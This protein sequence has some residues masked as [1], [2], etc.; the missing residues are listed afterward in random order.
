M[1]KLRLKTDKIV[2]LYNT[3]NIF[4]NEKIPFKSAVKI[5]TNIEKLKIINEQFENKRTE[6]IK[7]YGEKDENGEVI[8]MD[9][10][11]IKIE[12]VEAFNSSFN[13]ILQEEFDL[14]LEE[15]SM[16]DLEEIKV[17]ANDIYSISEILTE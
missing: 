7:E 14:E 11:R 4:A 3:L 12:N 13:K 2:G 8:V 1:K 6:L 15:L 10:N 5:A 16:N 17:S 9:D